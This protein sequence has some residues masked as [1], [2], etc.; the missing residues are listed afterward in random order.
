MRA[1]I[2]SAAILV[3]AA[4]IGWIVIPA[5][6]RAWRQIEIAEDPVALA[7]QRLADTINEPGVARE[8][9]AAL[10]AA[11][12]DLAASLIEIADAGGVRVDPAAR[13]QLVALRANPA[14]HALRDFGGGFVSGGGESGAAMVGA[15]TGDV[16]GYGD[17]RDLA[18][19]GAK[20]ASGEAIDPL[21]VGLAAAGLGL[22]VATWTSLGAALP[23]RGGLTLVKATQRAGRLSKPLVASLSRAAASA[24]DRE[25]L[26]RAAAAAGRLAP[27]EAA[28]AARGILRPAALAT[29]ERLGEN[30]ATLTARTGQRGARQVLALAETDAELARAAQIA[31]AKGPRTRAILALLGRGAL[32]TFTLT[33][34]VLGWLTSFALYLLG[35][36]FAARRFGL[37]LG[38]LRWRG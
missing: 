23:A 33:L 36:A 21:V 11:D 1:S 32:T 12:D 7:D 8:I 3:S 24:I 5:A 14:W 26:A 16:V 19:E 31:A 9:D 13:A 15:I 28:Q 18:H 37:W 22:S 4:A 27:I 17:L 20:A 38:R 2:T 35:L 29:F 34:T 30:V 10:T 25:A 6:S